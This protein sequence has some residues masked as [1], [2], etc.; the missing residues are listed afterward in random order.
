MAD[1][2]ELFDKQTI[3]FTG[4]SITDAGR[5]EVGVDRLGVGYVY[6]A[7]NLLKARNPQ[8]DLNIINTGISGDTT[9]ALKWRWDRD[10]LQHSPDILSV[11]IGINDLWYCHDDPELVVKGVEVEEYEDNCRYMLENAKTQCDCQIVIMEPFMFCNDATNPIFEDLQYY[12]AV[13][14]R[15]AEEFDAVLVKLQDGI[16]KVIKD[17]P[18][19]KW[20]D[21]MVHPYQWAHAWIADEW[22]RAAGVK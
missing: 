22:L 10:C 2:I 20:S 17:V 14:H 18:S 13:V 7:A 11:M 3:L 1:G 12:I 6:F 8:L 21:D 15:L 9:R 5:R 4:D 16:D 19:E